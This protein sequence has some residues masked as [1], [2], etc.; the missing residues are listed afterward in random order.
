MRALVIAGQFSS[1]FSEA[2]WQQIKERLAELGVDL[3]AETLGK[4]V[5]IPCVVIVALRDSIEAERGQPTRSEMAKRVAAARESRQF[6]ET[7]PNMLAVFERNFSDRKRRTSERT[8]KFADKELLNLRQGKG[9]KPYYP[10]PDGI[11]SATLCALIVSEKFDWPGAIN[12]QA[13]AACLVLYAAAGG[14]IKGTPNLTDEFPRDHL[15]GSWRRHLRLARHR[16]RDTVLSRR[17]KS[18]LIS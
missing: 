9:N 2:R 3:V 6:D 15:R 13:Q 10:R 1:S 16:W 18:A 14:D 7:D 4:L 12:R 11:D 5:E 8:R 17:I